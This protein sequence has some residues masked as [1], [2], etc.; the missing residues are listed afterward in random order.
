MPAGEAAGL[1]GGTAPTGALAYASRACTRGIPG[2]R[3]CGVA[4]GLGR[5]S[6]RGVRVPLSTDRT[7]FRIRDMYAQAIL[8]KVH[9]I[10]HRSFPLTWLYFGVQST[11]YKGRPMR[12]AV[13]IDL[14]EAD[15]LFLE[16]RTRSCN[17]SRRLGRVENRSGRRQA[18][19][20]RPEVG[21]HGQGARAGRQPPRQEL[22]G[23]GI[24]HKQGDPPN[25]ADRGAGRH[26]LVLPVRWCVRHVQRTESCTG[27]RIRWD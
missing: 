17:A 12:E 3:T 10:I 20:C 9:N 27:C 21:G 8:S 16:R 19:H 25:D 18:A 24:A 7:A 14:S 6:V 5:E 13:T 2:G 22:Q 15:R 26:P 11:G 1:F 4:V 23:T